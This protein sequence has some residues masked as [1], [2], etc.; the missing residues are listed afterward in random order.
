MRPGVPTITCAPASSASSCGAVADAAVDRQVR[1]AAVL[2]DALDLVRD[3]D[4]ELARRREH[5]HL[6]R[7]QRR[8]DR[9]RRWEAERAGLA[10]AGAACTIRSRAARASAG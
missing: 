4:R 10:A 9:S 3:L 1:D 7:A 2:A 5:Q 8:L 6:R